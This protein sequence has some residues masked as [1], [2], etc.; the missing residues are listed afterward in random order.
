[1]LK[2]NFV[3]LALCAL[4]LAGCAGAPAQAPAETAAETTVKTNAEAVT[5]TPPQKILPAMPARPP[6]PRLSGFPPWTGRET[7]GPRKIFRTTKLS[8]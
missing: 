1:M 5:E 4:L 7:A 6:P 2:K 8:C 3:P